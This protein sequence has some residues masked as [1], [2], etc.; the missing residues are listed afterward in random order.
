[1]PGSFPLI[2]NLESGKT[3]LPMSKDRVPIQMITPV[4][5]HLHRNMAIRK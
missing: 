2:L 4:L 5:L 1:M 3:L